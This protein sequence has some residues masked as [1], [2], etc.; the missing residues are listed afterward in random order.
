[1]LFDFSKIGNSNLKKNNLIVFVVDQ[2]NIDIVKR[3]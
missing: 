2:V 1:M 3:A